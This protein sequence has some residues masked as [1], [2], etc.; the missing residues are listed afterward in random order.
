MPLCSSSPAPGQILRRVRSGLVRTWAFV[1]AKL[2]L[3][4]VGAQAM[5]ET[6][7]DNLQTRPTTIR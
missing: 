6:G 5:A 4:L 7:V 2:S 1:L 3:F